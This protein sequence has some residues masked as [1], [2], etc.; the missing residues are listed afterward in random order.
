MNRKLAVQRVVRRH[1]VASFNSLVAGALK[2]HKKEASVIKSAIRE[3]GLANVIKQ[4]KNRKVIRSRDI[5]L[6][7][8]SSKP[9]KNQ[10]NQLVDIFENREEIARG[11]LNE[12]TLSKKASFLTFLGAPAWLIKTLAWLTAST[13]GFAV[14]VIACICIFGMGYIFFL[15]IADSLPSVFASFLGFVF[16]KFPLFIFKAVLTPVKFLYELTSKLEDKI[17]EEQSVNFED[18]ES[19]SDREEIERF[20]RSR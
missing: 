13:F 20:R 2:K 16:I 4:A 5:V 17:Q 1:K 19:P 3:V 7:K 12:D 8:I 6:D 15:I 14:L 18:L 9:H 11:L 10:F